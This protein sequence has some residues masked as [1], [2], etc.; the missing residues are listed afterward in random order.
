MVRRPSPEFARIA[1]IGVLTAA[2]ALA[3]VA[4]LR[5]DADAR[6]PVA[7]VAATRAIKPVPTPK[8]VPS[9]SATPGPIRVQ[10]ILPIDRI[11]FGDY[12]WDEKNV[13]PGPLTVTVDLKAQTLSVFRG[14]HEI[15]TSAIL[16]GANEKPTPLGSYPITAKYRDHVSN[17]YDAPMPYSLRLTNDGIMVHG[18][19]VAWGYATHGC[20]GV[21]V[22]FAKLLFEAAE[23]G[24]RVIIT[25]GRPL[26]KVGDPIA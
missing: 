8:P 21:P 25:S 14:G 3:V 6:A 24:D 22:K 19:E 9:P 5:P 17:I 23:K 18:T 11:A 7:K 1:A 12:L 10:R 26:L 16:Y 13:P 2:G 15:G 20:I 4:A